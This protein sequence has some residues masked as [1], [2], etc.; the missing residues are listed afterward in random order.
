MTLDPALHDEILVCLQRS[1]YLLESRLIRTLS[2][3]HFF[4]EP[5]I[6]ALDP[7][8]GKTREI[9]LA[10][11]FFDSE[12]ARHG[13]SVKTR[14]AIEAVS[15][16]LPLVLMTPHPDPRT[17]DFESYLKYGTTPDPCPLLDEADLY[18]VKPAFD[19]PHYSQFCCLSR[20]RKDD[21]LMASHSEDLYSSL[22]KL[23]EHID[24]EVTQFAALTWPPEDRFWRLWFWEGVLV[25]GGD[26]L[27]ASE[28]ENGT[29]SLT[30]VDQG[31]LIFNFHASD[32]PR[33]ALIQVVREPRLLSYL[34]AS[35]SIDNEIAL[36]LRALRASGTS[37]SPKA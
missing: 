21:A 13:I 35:V 32:Q 3:E 14:F 23:A 6:A 10:V 36:R 19:M 8:T 31:A 26:L 17:E 29:I 2:S 4:V 18:E 33:C 9:D 15:N 7:R 28:Q 30:E 20:K 34:N 16:D 24:Q 27:V 25:L 5:N 37:D 11:E 22:Q 1:G 12:S